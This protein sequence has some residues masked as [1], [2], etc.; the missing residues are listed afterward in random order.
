MA[1]QSAQHTRPDRDRSRSMAGFLHL[2]PVESDYP[3]LNHESEAIARQAS[4][5]RGWTVALRGR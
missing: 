5:A 4:V 3:L 1:R 2:P